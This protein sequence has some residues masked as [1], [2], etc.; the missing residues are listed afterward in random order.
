MKKI[1]L[2]VVT[3]ITLLLSGNIA[4]AQT[5][6]ET[7]TE[8]NQE[9]YGGIQSIDSYGADEI[10]YRSY[11]Q[12]HAG[13]EF[14]LAPR[15]IYV[16]DKA[17]PWYEVSC[18]KYEEL[19]TEEE[20]DYFIKKD[21]DIVQFTGRP[22]TVRGNTDPA[23]LL[24]AM[25]G[26]GKDIKLWTVMLETPPNG[27]LEEGIK[28]AVSIA[29]IKTGTR[30]AYVEVRLQL[31]PQNAGNVLPFGSG[32]SFIGGTTAWAFAANPQTGKSKSRVY[33]I[34]HITVYAYNDGPVT[35]SIKKPPVKDTLKPVFFNGNG[36]VMN[37]ENAIIN[38]VQWLKKRW[39]AI[40]EKGMK[41]QFS[42]LCL[43][44][45]NPALAEQIAY[46]VMLKVGSVLCEQGIN[47]TELENAFRYNAA[48]A[49]E[50][51]T[52]DLK[53]RNANGAVIIKITNS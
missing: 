35:P 53:N 9:M 29:K 38:N 44:E 27:L 40:K 50:K 49:N 19:Y 46:N 2:S 25:P 34:Y 28:R 23:Y 20:L 24:P 32:S 22:L 16:P 10:T 8:T 39:D 26:G 7:S 1:C 42:G 45:G 13:A 18:F 11:I 51:Q 47:E 30:R 17:R 5:N 21:G 33:N 12:P 43:P 41:I 15:A 48:T 14:L 3:I 37:Q 52:A 31:N 4:V 36:L 6:V